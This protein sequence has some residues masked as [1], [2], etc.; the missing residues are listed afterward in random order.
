MATPDF[1]GTV[2]MGADGPD[3]P[4]VRALLA[5]QEG[6]GTGVASTICAYSLLWVSSLAGHRARR[7]HNSSLGGSRW[8]YAA[9]ADTPLG[10]SSVLV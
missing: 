5:N 4:S 9:I 3:N 6:V 1:D 7:A 8:L 10:E 2:T